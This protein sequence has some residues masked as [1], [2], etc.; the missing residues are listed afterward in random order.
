MLGHCS[1]V[2]IEASAVEAVAVTFTPGATA[3]WVSNTRW[4]VSGSRRS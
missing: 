3:P 4:P 1:T 2:E